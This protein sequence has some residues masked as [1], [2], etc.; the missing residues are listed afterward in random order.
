MVSGK[1]ALPPYFSIGYHQSRWSYYS[2]DDV[3]LVNLR[4]DIFDIPYDVIWL[5]IDVSLF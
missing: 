3:S 5:D 1:G 4:F 2:A